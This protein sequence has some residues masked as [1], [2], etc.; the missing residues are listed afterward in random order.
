MLLYNQVDAVLPLDRIDATQR[1]RNGIGICMAMGP[2]PSFPSVQ[3]PPSLILVD[4]QLGS[5][6]LSCREK[7]A[8]DASSWRKRLA[9][10]VHL[11]D[12][13]LIFPV[14]KKIAI[15]AS[16]I[17]EVKSSSSRSVDYDTWAQRKHHINKERKF[18]GFCHARRV[19]LQFHYHARTGA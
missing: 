5:R 4:R 6:V 13:G 17:L 18:S 19:L 7:I 9:N 11:K 12:V 10:K 16:L 2:S 8:I 15:D 3:E 14:E 1:V